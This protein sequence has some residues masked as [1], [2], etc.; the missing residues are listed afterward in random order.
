M[1]NPTKIYEI[2]GEDWT[3]GLSLKSSF[4][5]GGIFRTAQNFDPFEDYGFLRS[6]LDS[7]T[8]NNTTD[9]PITI[10]NWNESGTAKLY[11]HTDDH[12]Y[13]VLSDSPY[14]TTDESAEIDVT[15]TVTGATLF[16]G[17]YIYAQAD[18]TEVFSNTLPVASAS[19]IK[20]FDSGGSNTAWWTPMAIAP[21]KNLYFAH[22]E[23]CRITKVSGGGETAA[24]N[25]TYYALESS[26]YARDLVSD[27]HYL[28]VVADNNTSNQRG[29]TPARGSYRCQ[30][31]FYD[32]NNGRSTADYIYEFTD[33]YVTS[34]RFLDGAIY[35]FGRENMWVCNA[36]TPP[37][38]V[39]SFNS[40]STIIE[41]PKTPFQVTQNINSLYWCGT[42]NNVIYAF[43][44]LTTGM[45]KV[46]YQ[47]YSASGVPAS[48]ATNGTLFYV[49]TSSASQMLSVLNTGS[50]RAITT[51]ATA[52]IYLPQAY[53][54]AFAKVIMKSKL[55]TG[56]EVYF[57]LTNNNGENISKNRTKTYSEIGAKQAIIFNLEN[58]TAPNVSIKEFNDF[59]LTIGSNQSVARV[60]IWATPVENYDQTV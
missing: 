43:G 29:A 49:G 54:F 53:K 2:K 55:A 21:D 42:T 18:T 6:S 50:S 35:I 22:G 14:T 19:N 58:D 47:P 36:V 34:V 44:S 32:V 39:F 10:T 40:T 7:A 5:V 15:G 12:L 51:S 56:G 26:M 28:V 23:I 16:K 48:I 9:T 60:E 59:R 24:N 30:V 4:P 33:S 37:K 17:R 25:G 52:S 11:V 20:I 13:E 45:K 41:P 3:K 46:F 31:L 38:P 8:A 27:G 1:A 57:G